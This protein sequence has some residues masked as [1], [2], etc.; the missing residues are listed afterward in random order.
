MNPLKS[1]LDEFPAV[2]KLMDKR[3]EALLDYDAY[4]DKVKKLQAKH[5]DKLQSKEVTKRG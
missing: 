1:Y 3:R 4:R 2:R 5:S